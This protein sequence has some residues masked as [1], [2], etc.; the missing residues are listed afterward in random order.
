MD[1]KEVD[2]AD[3]VNHDLR[4]ELFTMSGLRGKFPQV[5]LSDKATS[6]VFVGDFDKIQELIENNNLPEDVLKSNKIQSFHGV[7]APAKLG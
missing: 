7:F 1:F 5:F 3:P 2:A 6:T 4:T